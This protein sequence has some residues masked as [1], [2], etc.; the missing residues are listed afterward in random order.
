M[1]KAKPVLSLILFTLTSLLAAQNL[2]II[3]PNGGEILTLG[4]TVQITW[5]ANNVNQKVKLQ[6]IR[7]GGAQV[8]LIA[9]NLNATPSSFTWTIGQTDSGMAAADTNYKIRI[10][11]ADNALEDASNGTFTIA[12]ASTPPPPPPASTSPYQRYQ[13]ELQKKPLTFNAQVV[14]YAV[15]TSFTADGKTDA[16]GGKVDCHLPMG[17]QCQVGAFSKTQPILYSYKLIIYEQISG[18]SHVIKLSQWLEQNTYKFYATLE[19]V[20]DAA[21]PAGMPS[22]M[23][24]SVFGSVVVEVKNATQT[25]QPQSRHIQIKLYLN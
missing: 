14:P 11:T 5:T 22:T 23:P 25:E 8:G 4:Q 6:L 15:L 1:K 2:V 21:F 10:R 13:P 19:E 16:S 17:I 20:T 9:G 3:A 18:M 7:G 12:A 24:F